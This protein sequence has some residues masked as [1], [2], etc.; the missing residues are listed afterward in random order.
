MTRT[1]TAK[2]VACPKCS[3][4]TEITCVRKKNEDTLRIRYRKCPSCNHKFKTWQQVTAGP[5]EI[6]DYPTKEELRIIHSFDRSS[7]SEEDVLEIMDQL[8]K[9]FWLRKDIALQYGVSTAVIRDIAV[10]KTFKHLTATPS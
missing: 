7:L 6:K 5:E 9:G 1:L 4:T 2:H 8:K 10:G 3:T